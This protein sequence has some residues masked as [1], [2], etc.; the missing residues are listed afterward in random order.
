MWF[1]KPSAPHLIEMF[2]PVHPLIVLIYA[3]EFPKSQHK[4]F[5]AD[6]CYNLA[7]ERKM[8]AVGISQRIKGS[9][10]LVSA[11]EKSSPLI[12]CLASL[13]S[14]FPSPISP[15]QAVPFF[16]VRRIIL[17]MNLCRPLLLTSLN[18]KALQ[19]LLSP[20]TNPSLFVRT[21]L[22]TSWLTTWPCVGTR[23]VFKF[24]I[25]CESQCITCCSI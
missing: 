24:R 4:I 18:R 13:E 20:A 1:V 16:R 12:L 25:M 10:L 23:H 6:L 5:Q 21:V 15:A 2:S 11:S 3:A 8:D 9:M 17:H 14:S 7:Q 19:A 22:N